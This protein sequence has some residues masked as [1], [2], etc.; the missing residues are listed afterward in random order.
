MNKAAFIFAALAVSFI[1]CSREPK[2]IIT[3]RSSDGRQIQWVYPISRDSY[4]VAIDSNGDSRP[5]IIKTFEN[6]EL[7]QIERDRNFDGT[8]DLVQEYVRGTLTREIHDDNFDGKPETIDHF[9]KSKLVMV[10][11]DPKE[12][13]L[14]DI[15]EY[16]NDLGKLTRREV[17]VR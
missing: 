14:I 8:A 6:K 10:E 11:R 4:K 13:G 5:D 9:R 7:L 3:Q 12:R 1:S 16:Y 2:G 17:R 15:V